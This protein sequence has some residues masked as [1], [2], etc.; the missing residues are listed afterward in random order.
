MPAKK[1]RKRKDEIPLTIARS[2]SLTISLGISFWDQLVKAA[3][4][5]IAIAQE[6]V[7]GE[8]IPDE[9][10]VTFQG[11]SICVDWSE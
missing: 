4:E 10:D 8:A 5:I 9:A 6:G 7:D 2:R 11:D 3:N 1:K